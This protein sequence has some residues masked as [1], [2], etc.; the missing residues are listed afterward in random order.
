MIL[1]F[2][3]LGQG[4]DYA[5]K[6]RQ[7]GEARQACFIK[8]NSFDTASAKSSRLRF[9]H[10]VPVGLDEVKGHAR[11]RRVIADPPENVAS[12]LTPDAGRAVQGPLEKPVQ[13]RA[14]VRGP[15]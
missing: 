13:K 6:D 7:T 1:G 2:Q 3:R 12:V 11:S 15:P 9:D 5:S 14:T 4:V 10:L 8:R